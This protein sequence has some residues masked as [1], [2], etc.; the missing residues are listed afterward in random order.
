MKE[1][2]NSLSPCD[3]FLF[4][5]LSPKE[6]AAAA[7]SLS[8]PVS[9]RKGERVFPCADNTSALG[10]LLAGNAAVLR[11]GADGKEQGCHRLS[12][13]DAFGAATLFSD[14]PAVSIVVAKSDCTVQFFSE[15]V[16]ITLMHTY[17]PVG[18][19]L[20]RFLTDRIRYLNRSLNGLRGGTAAQRLWTF[21]KARAD[22]TG[23]VA[24]PSMAAVAAALD[25]GRTSL[26]RAF[27]ELEQAGVLTRRGKTVFLNHSL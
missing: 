7:G 22:N 2:T 9:F 14:A 25:M 3:C 26:Y 13:G 1:E 6:K 8:P 20:I 27:E 10:I 15:S 18:E 17:P 4:E 23:A 21:L 11:T 24:L 19:N 12:I 16:L 5:K